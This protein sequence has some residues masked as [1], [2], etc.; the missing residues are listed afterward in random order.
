MVKT[1]NPE[2]MFKC[3]TKLHV[4]K[5]RVKKNG[6]SSLY[7]QVYISSAHTHERDFFPLDLEWPIDRIDFENGRLLPKHKDDP[8]VD[9]FN[10]IILTERSKYN[11]VSKIY[12][13]SERH[14]T[15][16]I[17]KREML[18]LD[19]TRSVVAYFTKIRE[20]LY[21]KRIITHETYKH[22]GATI[23]RIE[24]FQNNVR[25]DQIN[26]RWIEKFKA[27]LKDKGN[28]HNTVW[29]RVKEMKAMLRRAN[30][31]VTIHVDN[32]AIHYSN[33]PLE[34]PTVFLNRIE[35]NLL[36]D[37]LKTGELTRI[38]TAVLKAFLFSCFT[39]LRIS[40]VY[41]ADKTWFLSDNFLFFTM[42]KNKDRRPKTIKIPIAPMA[43]E[44]I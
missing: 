38:E 13:L 19:S 5:A 18:F 21:R 30:E 26:K 11:E 34:T 27:F 2:P 3:S 6:N 23:N 8:D 15:I 39:S 32:S 24:E 1:R 42:Q 29:T 33:R 16:D 37:K 20:E 14:L 44:F 25:F 17:L 36:K 28:G 31:E 43:I 9:D 35:V 41:Q 10:M 4:W 40:D 7:I 22:Y 12:R